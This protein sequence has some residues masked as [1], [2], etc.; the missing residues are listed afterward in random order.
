MIRRDFEAEI[1]ELRARIA[2]L[3][4]EAANNER[5]L[6]K[7]Q[8]RELELLKAESLPE[9]FET[10]G[11]GLQAAYTLDAVTLTLCDPDHEIRHLLIA[12]RVNVDELK[13]VVFADSLLGLAPQFTVL[14][15]PW[16]GP[17]IGAD[18]QLLFAGA[19]DLKSIALI[20]LRRHER[21][22][23]SINFG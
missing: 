22:L 13:A 4:E 14:H 15:K 12:E 9:L 11:S 7:T 17:Y 8:T 3:M 21:L 18:H 23:G 10:I 16:L 6:K 1:R 2:T 19:P 20:P 5:L